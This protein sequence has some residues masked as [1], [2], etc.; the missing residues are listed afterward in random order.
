MTGKARME[1]DHPVVA[2]LCAATMHRVRRGDIVLAGPR[3]SQAQAAP[4]A[5]S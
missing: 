2:T 4:I 1:N 3:G 5:P